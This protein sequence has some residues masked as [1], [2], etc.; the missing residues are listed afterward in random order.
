MTLPLELYG[1]LFLGIAIALLILLIIYLYK[2]YFRDNKISIIMM[3]ASLF[4]TTIFIVPNISAVPLNFTGTFNNTLIITP[5]SITLNINNQNYTYP[6]T[7]WNYS[8]STSLT[9]N[10]E[11]NETIRYVFNETPKINYSLININVSYLNIT[12]LV[13]LNTSQVNLSPILLCPDN[14]VTINYNNSMVNELVES[15]MPTKSALTVCEQEKENAL[16]TMNEAVLSRNLTEEKYNYALKQIDN[17]RFKLYLMIY[18]VLFCILIII[19]LLLF[20]GGGGDA[21]GIFKQWLRRGQ[22][23]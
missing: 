16:N 22:Q 5:S 20:V 15:L 9:F 6:N 8:I 19:Y 21:L 17:E 13:I 7:A 12:T 1:N 14:N 18:I 23:Q 3:G 4:F 10:I 2:T 11:I